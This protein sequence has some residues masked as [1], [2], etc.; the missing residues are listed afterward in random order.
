MI[1]VHVHS[2]YEQKKND[3]LVTVGDLIK[4]TNH[5]RL[6]HGCKEIHQWP[7]N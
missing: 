4:K 6:A 5:H 2:F 1:I 3:I 7:I